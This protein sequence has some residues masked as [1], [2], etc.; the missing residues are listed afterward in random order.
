MDVSEPVNGALRFMGGVVLPSMKTC[1]TM[2]SLTTNT[3]IGI[4]KRAI[5][6]AASI[7]HFVH[8]SSNSG[9]ENCNKQVIFMSNSSALLNWEI[10][11]L[12]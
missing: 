7:R 2:M 6:T 9:N 1:D 3:F 10:L 8:C 4:K 5:I 12:P 11:I